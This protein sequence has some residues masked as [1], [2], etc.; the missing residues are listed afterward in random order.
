[1]LGVQSFTFQCENPSGLNW[2]YLAMTLLKA[3]F[4]FCFLA[5]CIRN[6]IMYCV[7]A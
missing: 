3:L 6:T 5:R 4:F 2:L 7:V 1:M